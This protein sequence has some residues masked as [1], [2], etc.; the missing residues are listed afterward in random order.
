MPFLSI[1]ITSAILAIVAAF[2]LL[3]ATMPSGEGSFGAA[4]LAPLILI[5]LVPVCFCLIWLPANL[6]V[7]F[8]ITREKRRRMADA[9]SVFAFSGILFMAA[10]ALS[11]NHLAP[12]W[13]H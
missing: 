13:L 3:N 11:G 7:W 1:F 10:L 6:I 2:A 8:S 5:V 12:Q 4:K 9:Q